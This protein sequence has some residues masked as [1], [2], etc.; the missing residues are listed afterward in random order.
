VRRFKSFP[1]QVKEEDDGK[2]QSRSRP[3]EKREEKS[4][5]NG[6]PKATRT[7][8]V[9]KGQTETKGPTIRE[10]SSDAA[11]ETG[12]KG[13]ANDL[14]NWTSESEGGV[15]SLWKEDVEKGGEPGDGPDPVEG[16]M[17]DGECAMRIG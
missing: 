7:S 16:A 17:E 3:N 6:K 4:P 2:N 14:W 5:G 15:S 10:G 13:L 11:E 12:G 8:E 9:E 1:P